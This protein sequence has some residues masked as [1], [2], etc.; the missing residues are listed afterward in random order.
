[1]LTATAYDRVGRYPESEASMRQAELPC[2]V[3]NPILAA[4]LATRRGVI[5][6]DPTAAERDFGTALTIA[7]QHHD[8]FREAGSLSN[9]AKAA[10]D[11]EHYDESVA[12]GQTSLQISRTYGYRLYA[13]KAEGNLAWAFYKLGDY[14]QALAF[15]SD[16]EAAARELGA[17]RDETHFLNIMGMIHEQNRQLAKA[18]SEYQQVL[19]MAQEQKD[20]DHTTFALS[21]LAFLS[22]QAA[23][24]NEAKRFSEQAFESAHEEKDIPMQLEALLAQGIVASNQGDRSTAENLLEEVARDPG[25]DR[26]SVRWEAQSALAGL[27]ADEH[28]ITSAQA[29]YQVALNTVRNARCSVQQEGLRLPFFANATRVYNRYIDFLVQQGK[30]AEAL[31]TADESRALTLAEGLGIEGKKCLASETVFNPQRSARDAKA[32]ILFYWLGADHSYLWAVTPDRMKLY[33]LPLAEQIEA[34]VQAYRKALVGSRDVLQTGDANGATLYQTLVAPAEAFFHNDPRV[35]GQRV[36]VIA[37]G[38]LS[39]LNFETLIDPKPQPH[40]WID[41]VCVENASSLRLLAAGPEKRER[42][43]GKLLLIGNPVPPSAGGFET[44]PNAAKEMESVQRYFPASGMLVFERTNSTPI[45]YLGSHPE[46]FAYIHFVA[47][48]VASLTDPLDS[49]VVLSPPP[50][51]G[52]DGGYKLYARDVMTH[53]L[54]AELVTVST[55]KGAGVR[56]YTGEGLVGLSWA[57]LHAGAHHV[58]GALWDVSDESTPQLMAAMYGELVRGTPPDAALRTAK[59]TLLRSG[60]PFRKPYYWAPFQLYTGS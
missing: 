20:K 26:Q 50:S 9:L 38:T 43:T 16:A 55:C 1:M 46:Q 60:A 8:S 58:I 12:L 25:V 3:A 27:Y 15:L 57:F 35:R 56:T 28:K 59:L 36:I 53:P 6:D 31:R 48:G 32:T 29:E 37:D 41:D 19:R 21:E 5:L 23:E 39:S 40:Y 45:A 4:D 7:R 33:P 42:A 13:E 22:I 24:W 54:K 44:L 47:H 51:P 17:K 49:A 18:R 52:K 14:G 11:R 30:M 10:M 34:A 2:P